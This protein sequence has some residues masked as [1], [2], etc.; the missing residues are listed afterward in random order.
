MNVGFAKTSGKL[1]W[2]IDWTQGFRVAPG[3]STKPRLAMGVEYKLLSFLPFRSGFTI[4]GDRNTAFSFGSGVRFFGFYF[5]AAVITG[6]SLSV[7]SA[8]GANLSISTGLLF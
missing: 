4:G 8:K 5:D 6:T 7:Y 1:L 3:S 2:A